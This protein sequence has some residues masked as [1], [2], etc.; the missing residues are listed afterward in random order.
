MEDKSREELIEESL[1][2]CNDI[3]KFYKLE[4]VNPLDFETYLK[5]EDKKEEE[6]KEHE[7]QEITAVNFEEAT[8]KIYLRFSI[9]ILIVLI[10]SKLFNSY[11]M[12]ETIV[13]GTSMFPT[14]NNSDRLLLDKFT[15]KISKLKRYDIIVFGYNNVDLYIKRVIGLPGEEVKIADGK[16]FIDGKPLEDDPCG[17]EKMEFY[18]IAKNGVILRD[19]E[20]F[21]L[22][23]NRN[24]SYDSRFEQVGVVN[25]EEILGRVFFRFYPFSRIGIIR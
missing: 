6:E 12:E 23:D 1:E 15:Y 9:F 14:L 24:N 22:G 3:K 5:N 18:G 17:I 10:A 4:V 13:N 8:F 25:E 7:K 2:L 20:Y 19:N 11:I 16:V 21:V